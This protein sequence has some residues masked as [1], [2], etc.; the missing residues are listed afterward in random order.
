[1]R[2]RVNVYMCVFTALLRT[3]VRSPCR[4]RRRRVPLKIPYVQFGALA[5][6]S[7]ASIRRRPYAHTHTLVHA[8][9]H[10]PASLRERLPVCVSVCSCVRESMRTAHARHGLRHVSGNPSVKSANPV[11]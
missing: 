7:D 10:L 2:V 9:V 4:R 6:D 8:L 1:M 11:P 5:Y 3:R